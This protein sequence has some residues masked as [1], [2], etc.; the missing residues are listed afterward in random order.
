M[1]NIEIRA[2][3]QNPD[4]LLLKKHFEKNYPGASLKVVYKAGFCGFGIQRS[5]TEM[6]LSCILV[7]AADVPTSDK[8]RKRKDELK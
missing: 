7:N 5:L 2:F 1:N 6:G 3:S 4:S 8:D